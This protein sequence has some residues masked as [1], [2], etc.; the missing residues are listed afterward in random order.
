MRLLHKLNESTFAKNV[1]VLVGGTALSQLIAIIALPIL[2]RIFSPEDFSVLA[3][4]ASSLALVSVVSCL[5]LEIAIPIPRYENVAT[6]LVILSLLGLILVTTSVTVGVVVLNI[7]PDNIITSKLG[8]YLW[9]LPIAVLIVGLFNTA[10]FWATRRKKFKV[11]SVTRI[12][13]SLAGVSTQLILGIFSLKATGLVLGHVVQGGAGAVK[14]GRLLFLDIHG[15][16][17]LFNILR[18]KATLRR[19]KRFVT[20]SSIEAL[21]NN[22]AIHLPVILIATYAAGP[23]AGF[24]LLSIKLL[25]APM[26]LVGSA[27]GQVYLSEAPKKREL[28]L[29]FKFTFDTTKK[30]VKLAIIPMLI[31]CVLSPYVIPFIFGEKWHPAGVYISWMTP[32]F[33]MQFIVSPISMSLHICNAQKIAMLLQIF[34]VIFRCGL[35]LFSFHALPNYVVEVFALSGFVFYLLYLVIVLRVVSRF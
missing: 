4:F 9:F 32:W 15:R 7:Y 29:L 14:L 3:I 12:F 17:K 6:R 34:G 16:Y 10:Q 22:A 28:G 21:S 27:V 31:I 24:L 1:S 35:V 5:R 8:G 30:L 23:V 26:S 19:F 18:L 11:I 33:F 13:Q 20:Y 2:T 25:S